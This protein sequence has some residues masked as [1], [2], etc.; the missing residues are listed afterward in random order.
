MPRDENREIYYRLLHDDAYRNMH[1]RV[2]GQAGLDRTIR[3]LEVYLGIEPEQGSK[4]GPRL[5]PLSDRKLEGPLGKKEWL[6]QATDL[7]SSTLEA[8]ALGTFLAIIRE[9][10]S[11]QETT[12]LIGLLR[13]HLHDTPTKRN[14][15]RS[16]A[17]K[18]ASADALL[19]AQA[20]VVE[21]KNKLMEGPLTKRQYNR[22]QRN[23]IR[24]SDLMDKILQRITKE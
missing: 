18:E 7:L 12:R 21:I 22:L 11:L 17:L 13:T 5:P 9:K 15:D 16:L 2:L 19:G 6:D 4:Q 1:L 10:P 8:Y 20:I 3:W 14:F 23:I 24:A